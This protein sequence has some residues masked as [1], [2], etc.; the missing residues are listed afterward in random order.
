METVWPVLGIIAAILLIV[1]G[2]IGTLLPI[3]PG[4]PLVFFG[5]WLIA[6]VDHYQ[7]IGWPTLTLLGAIVVVT[8]IVDFVASAVGAKKVGASR[9]AVTGA[10]LGSIIGMFFGIPG[11]LL[12]PFIGAVVGELMA[13]RQVERATTVGIAT[14]LGL[15][16]GSIAKLALCLAMLLIFAFAWWL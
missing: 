16:A 14:W 10:L 9:Q 4:A 3:V 15:L 12:G 8:V 6:L 1:V 2:L 13:Q 5:L 7:H 11:L